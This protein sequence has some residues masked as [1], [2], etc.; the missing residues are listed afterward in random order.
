MPSDITFDVDRA[1]VKP[2]F[3]TT[4]TDVA[5]TLR[6]YESTSIDV[7]GHADF[8][9]ADAYNQSL[10]ERRANAVAAYLQSAGVQGPRIVAIGFGETRPV[11]SNDT[12]QGRTQNRRVEI[13]PRPVTQG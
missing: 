10:S 3:S 12:A 4:L 13:K 11:A 8:T 7:I 5:N 6:Q 1:D 9:G 2:Q